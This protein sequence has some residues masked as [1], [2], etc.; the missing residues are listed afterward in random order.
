[1]GRFS[2]TT[3]VPGL[4]PGRTRHIHVKVQAPYQ[5]ILTTQL[6]F[7]G[8]PRNGSDMLFDPEL[9]MEVQTGPG[10]RP[11]TFDFV[12]QVPQ[13]GRRAGFRQRSRGIRHPAGA[14]ARPAATA[15]CRFRP[16]TCGNATEP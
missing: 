16:K 8:E 3:I 7:P 11:A 10:G 12:L 9:L 2:L 14:P 1:M 15:L 6:Y 5:R 4:R 13:L